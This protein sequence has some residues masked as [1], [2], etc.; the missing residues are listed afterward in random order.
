MPLALGQLEVQNKRIIPGPLSSMYKVNN[1]IF[2]LQEYVLF[3]AVLTAF[4]MK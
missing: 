3:V 1:T 2:V 4:W